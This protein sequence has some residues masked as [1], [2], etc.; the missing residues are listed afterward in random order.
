M[1]IIAVGKLKS[2]L[3]IWPSS[4]RLLGTGLLALLL[5]CF[6]RIVVLWECL[7]DSN[8]ERSPLKNVICI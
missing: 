7:E 4:E 3:S 8:R 1:A 5:V 2:K 6:G